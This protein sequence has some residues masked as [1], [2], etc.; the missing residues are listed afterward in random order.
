MRHKQAWRA[1]TAASCSRRLQDQSRN[2]QSRW[3]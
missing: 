3:A 2:I 1:T